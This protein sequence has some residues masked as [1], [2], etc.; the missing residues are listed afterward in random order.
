MN[1]HKL[2]KDFWMLKRSWSNLGSTTIMM[3]KI[4]SN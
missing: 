4:Q 3:M 1:S 2:V